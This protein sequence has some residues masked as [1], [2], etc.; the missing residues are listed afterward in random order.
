MSKVLVSC[1]LIGIFL[2][3]ANVYAAGDDLAD[4][5]TN[6]LGRGIVN[7]L[8][9][10]VELPVQ[11]AKGYNEGFAGNENNKVVG[12]LVGI[13]DGIS[14]AAGRTLSGAGD[15]VGFWAADPKDNEGV[16]LP[17]DAE[18]AWETGT[19]YN[20]FEPDFGKGAIEPIGN[21]LIRG[22]GDVVLGFVE[23]PGQIS[24][25]LK[26]GAPDIGIFK[27]IWYMLSREISGV[28][29]ITTFILPGPKDTKGLAFDQ[30]RS[31][32]ALTGSE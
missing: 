28:T 23:I 5:A 3:A 16:G 26:N 15:V 2:F 20:A 9:G 10:W 27:G 31:W 7:V 6:K 25:G 11:I 32:D 8:T 24:Q 4:G 30:E 21:K 29:D 17:L 14:H 12:A 13:F 22:I 19:P 18:Y 1:A